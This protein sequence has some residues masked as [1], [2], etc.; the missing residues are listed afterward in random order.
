MRGEWWWS[1]GARGGQ[2]RGCGC[3]RGQA[4]LHLRCSARLLHAAAAAAAAAAAPRQDAVPD[5]NLGRGRRRPDQ[6]VTARPRCSDTT[7]LYSK[8]TGLCSMP[9]ES[10]PTL[11]L[12]FRAAELPG[13][14]LVGLRHCACGALV[15]CRHAAV[16]PGD[17]S[18][19]RSMLAAQKCPGR[20][21]RPGRP[22]FLRV[23]NAI[24]V[25]PGGVNARETKIALGQLRSSPTEVNSSAR[26]QGRLQLRAR[27]AGPKRARRTPFLRR[28]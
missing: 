13:R 25:R 22:G 11:P 20:P 14:G 19:P 24:S 27:L 26:L 17:G 15:Y 9:A 21:G 18:N 4:W 6:L 28:A 12:C 1:L 8:D 10:L 2:E 3:R 7:G 23:P 16:S 5:C